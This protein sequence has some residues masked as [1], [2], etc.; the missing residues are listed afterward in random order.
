MELGIEEGEF[1]RRWIGW[2]EEVET[3]VQVDVR[4]PTLEEAAGDARKVG[5]N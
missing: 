2:L 3:E 1:V 5:V 4:Y